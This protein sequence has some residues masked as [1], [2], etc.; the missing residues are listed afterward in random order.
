M[1]L[2]L[3]TVEKPFADQSS[4][5][6]FISSTLKQPE[7]GVIIYSP[8]QKYRWAVTYIRLQKTVQYKYQDSKYVV[9]LSAVGEHV[10]KDQ[11]H[12]VIMPQNFN[13]HDEISVCKTKSALG[14]VCN[15]HSSSKTSLS[16]F[17]VTMWFNTLY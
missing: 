1:R 12:H 7:P 14:R 17:D 6:E 13:F 4:I 16:G 9:E 5:Q 10:L 8:T 2:K 11:T 15:T 3:S